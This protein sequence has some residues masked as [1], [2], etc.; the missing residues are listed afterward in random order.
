MVNMKGNKLIL[1]ISSILLLTISSGLLF[2]KN[3]F[4]LE[5]PGA[6]GKVDFEELRYADLQVNSTVLMMR[7]S[8]SSDQS[9]LETEINR[10]KELLNIVTD[11]NKTTSELGNSLNKLHAYFDKK[12]SELTV[13]QKDLKELKTAVDSLNPGYNELNKNN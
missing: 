13:F 12:M 2:Y 1:L 6:G 10:I 11:V 5:S 7:K 4:L 3:I 8:L 9:A